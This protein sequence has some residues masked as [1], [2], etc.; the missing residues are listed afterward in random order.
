LQ[1][2]G[3]VGTGTGISTVWLR[4]KSYSCFVAFFVRLAGLFLV[5]LVFVVFLAFLVVVVRLETVEEEEVIDVGVTIFE[6]ISTAFCFLMVDNEDPI[7][8]RLS[9]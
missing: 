9:I 5:F 7:V 3:E 6:G 1:L 2:E 8:T 4:V